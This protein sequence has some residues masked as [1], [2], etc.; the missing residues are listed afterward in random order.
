MN[1]LPFRMR[2]QLLLISVSGLVACR[3]AED[4][5]IRQAIDSLALQVDSLKTRLW[6]AEM[7]FSFDS[8]A[9]LTPGSEGYQIVLSDLGKLTVSLE[10]VQPYANGSR[11]RLQIGNLTNATING[12]KTRLEWGSVDAR[13]FTV[14]STTRSREVKFDRPLRPGRWN[15][16]SVVLDAVPPAQLGFVRIGNVLHEG[17]E[18]LR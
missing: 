4:P 11:I 3:P 18:L 1:H 2:R 13:G 7:Q 17:I 14:D 16:I 9:Y 8:T 15:I 6:A 12:A 10:D 5:T